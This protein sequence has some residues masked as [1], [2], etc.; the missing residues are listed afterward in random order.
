[1]HFAVLNDLLVGECLAK[2][3]LIGIPIP[4]RSGH[5]IRLPHRHL[6]TVDH[7][8]TDIGEVEIAKDNP[9]DEIEHPHQIAPAAVEFIENF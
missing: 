8:L 4:S 2:G 9:S 5:Q 7:E 3:E 6:Q 1:V